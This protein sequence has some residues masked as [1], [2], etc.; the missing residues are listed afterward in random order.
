M[1][2]SLND[3]YQRMERVIAHINAH[4][5]EDLNLDDLADVACLSRFH[6]H[7]VY[8]GI[9]GETIHSTVKRLKL[10]RA[11]YALK[12]SDDSLAVIAKRAGYTR[13]ESFARAFK[14]QLGHTPAAF[15]ASSDLVS[16]IS[17]LKL[18]SFAVSIQT[19]NL[20]Y[21]IKDLPSIR[22]AALH[23]RGGY[24]GSSAFNRLFKHAIKQNIPMEGHQMVGL[25]YDDPALMPADDLRSIAG[26]KVGDD[27]MPTAPLEIFDT[28]AGRY[29]VF[30]YKGPY[31]RTGLAYDWIFG[32]W[33]PQSG[34]EAAEEP[35]LHISL[36]T[37]DTTASEDLLTDICIPLKG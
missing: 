35:S 8:R 5:D 18:E 32:R 30:H 23:N 26:I 10:N 20:S 16:R 4:L 13:V 27:F 2:I 11:S 29:A 6:W 1:E 3:Y 7:R 28:Y 12:H 31:E 24:N 36:N 21:D 34:E 25:Y 14:A 17:T 9:T 19:E 33:M 15:R 37:P 22:L